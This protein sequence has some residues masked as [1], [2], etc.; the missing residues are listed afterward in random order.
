MSESIF[1]RIQM[2][3]SRGRVTY[4]D[5]SGPVQKLQV[6]L[7]G[8]ETSD[9]RLRMQEFGFT[10][11]PPIGTD[12]LGLHISGDRSAGTVFATNH[13]QSRPTGL[14]AGETM[15]YSQDGKHVY[16]TASGGIVVEAKGQDVVVNDAANVTWNCSGDFTL[17]CGGKFNVVAPGGSKFTTPTVQSTG[18]MQDNTATNSHTMA[19]M[20]SIYNGH[21][22]PVASIQTGGSTINSNPPNQTE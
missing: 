13:Q 18:D 7:S 11:S 6:R 12:V 5:D 1:R 21:T 3:F 9:G 14:V 10:S 2:M 19:Q 16:L 17:N 8:L 4:V 20:R 15:L 22:H